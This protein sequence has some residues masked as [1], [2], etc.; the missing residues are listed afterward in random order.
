MKNSDEVNYIICTTSNYG[1]IVHKEA[2][3]VISQ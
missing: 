2:D 1:S 3:H